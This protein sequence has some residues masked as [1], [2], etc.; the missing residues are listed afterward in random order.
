MT[1]SAFKPDS[2]ATK[3]HFEVVNGT[4]LNVAVYPKV[5]HAADMHDYLSGVRLMDVLKTLEKAATHIFEDADDSLHNRRIV[6]DTDARVTW[7]S[8]N[9]LRR[10]MK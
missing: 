2:T 6:R 1:H 5:H 3:Y 9:E 10:A 4:D 7:F 8:L